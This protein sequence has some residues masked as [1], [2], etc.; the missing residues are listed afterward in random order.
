MSGP[1]DSWVVLWRPRRRAPWHVQPF[2]YSELI[3]ERHARRLGA[4]FGVETMI[5]PITFPGEDAEDPRNL[6]AE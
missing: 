1:S 4:E 6:E 3:A 2:V 5:H